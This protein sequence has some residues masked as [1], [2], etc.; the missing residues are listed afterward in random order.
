MGLFF[1]PV[2]VDACGGETAINCRIWDSIG[3]P[4]SKQ[5]AFY[6]P[7]HSRYVGC[8]IPLSVGR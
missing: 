1:N 2:V 8:P 3:I 7:F 6:I 5:F 4:L